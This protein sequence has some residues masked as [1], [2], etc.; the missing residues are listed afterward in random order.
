MFFENIMQNIAIHANL[1]H[2]FKNY[3]QNFQIVIV[4]VNNTKNAYTTF[5]NFINNL[6][7]CCIF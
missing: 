5:F 2:K 7:R 3:F 4:N 1:I 6:Q